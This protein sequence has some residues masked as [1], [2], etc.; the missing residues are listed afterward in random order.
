M[1]K[2]IKVDNLPTKFPVFPTMTMYLFLDKVNAAGWV[3]GAV[4]FFFVMVWFFALKRW[5]SEEQVDIFNKDKRTA[6]KLV[7][8]LAKL[9]TLMRKQFDELKKEKE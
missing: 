4:G 3:W 8:E 1:K 7:D 2:V 9:P 5:A 6:Q